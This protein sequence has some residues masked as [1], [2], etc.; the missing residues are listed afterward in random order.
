MAGG[1]RVSSVR[2]AGYM[3][4]AA[5]RL[6]DAA[7]CPGSS[8]SNC[9]WP[10]REPSL[11][12]HLRQI[13]VCASRA[14]LRRHRSGYRSA[15]YPQSTYSRVSEIH[16]L[17]GGWRTELLDDE[18]QVPV[19]S[20][21]VKYAEGP[22]VDRQCGAGSTRP[23]M[24]GSTVVNVMFQLPPPMAWSVLETLQAKAHPTTCPLDGTI[25][26]LARLKSTSRAILRH[27]YH[28]RRVCLY[29]DPDLGQTRAEKF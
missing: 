26:S 11:Y 6:S 27:P 13:H 10:R 4:S 16:Q 5:C 2:S 25:F 28:G 15:W 12:R 8:S 1:P 3:E 22:W 14:H 20:Y 19:R 17:Q 21:M 18:S 24:I 23:T 9:S 7:R 29:H